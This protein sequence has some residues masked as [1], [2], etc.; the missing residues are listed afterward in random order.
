MLHASFPTSSRLARTA[1]TTATAD[2]VRAKPPP[3]LLLRVCRAVSLTI[4]LKAARAQAEE[5]KC[6]SINRMGRVEG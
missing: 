4:A 1:S 5:V 2:S 6:A 3:L